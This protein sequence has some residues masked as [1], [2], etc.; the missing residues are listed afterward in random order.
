MKQARDTNNDQQDRMSD[1]AGTVYCLQAQFVQVRKE[2][3]GQKTIG[4]QMVLVGRC[5]GVIWPWLALA[6]AKDT[7]E[8]QEI[9][10]F[11]GGGL[12]VSGNIISLTLWSCLGR[13]P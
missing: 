10:H 6:G 7:E 12:L 3:A 8:K 2:G 1:Q 5:R 9:R 11:V 13:L 4:Y